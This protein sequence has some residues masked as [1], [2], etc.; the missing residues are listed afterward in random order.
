VHA[1][2]TDNETFFTIMN[3]LLQQKKY[4]EKWCTQLLY[5]SYYTE[6]E[7]STTEKLLEQCDPTYQ[8]KYRLFIDFSE[9]QKELFSKFISNKIYKDESINIYKLI[10][11]QQIINDDIT[12]RIINTDRINW[13]FSFIQELLKRDKIWLFYKELTY[14]FNNYYLEKAIENI[15]ITSKMTNKTELDTIAKQIISI[16]NG[17]QLIWYIWL[18]NQVNKNL[19]EKDIVINQENSTGGNYEQKI[20]NLLEQIK[21]MEINKSC[22][23]D[24]TKY[25]KQ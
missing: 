20:E 23:R 6:K 18:K 10:S 13:Y 3:T 21:D 4:N 17:N 15:E 25:H 5:Y 24:L 14:F 9:V 19:L 22:W 1:I 16:N 12:N 11:F 8:E 7:N 2:E